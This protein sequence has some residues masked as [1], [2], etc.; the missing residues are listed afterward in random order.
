MQAARS[1]LPYLQVL[2]AVAALVVAFLH[3]E[4]AA[5]AFAGR[6]GESPFPWLKPLP[7]EAGVDI[8]FVISGFVMVWSSMRLFGRRQGARLFLG[9]R[10]ARIVPLYWLTTTAVVLL[11]LT[12]PGALS[13]PLGDDWRYIAASYLFIPWLRPDGYI[14]PAFRLGWTL[15]YE[16][17]FYIIFCLFLPFQ[18]RVAV[19]GVCGVIALLALIGWTVPLGS[20]QLVFWAD[21][22]VLEFAFG[23][24]LG[25]IAVEGAV[26]AAPWRALLVAMAIVLFWLNP[27]EY[28]VVRPISYGIPA[29]LLVAAAVFAPAGRISAWTR[30]WVVLGDASYALYLAHPFPMRALR[31]VWMR[32]HL[33]GSLGIF[34]YIVVSV[35]ASCA[36]SVGINAWFERP[37][38]R[39]ARQFLRA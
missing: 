35:G 25:Y 6:P 36:L 37:A 23:V 8:F 30:S 31:E 7:W 32:M 24:L 4:Q 13:E 22:I 38:T 12:V 33:I 21:P 14:Q 34:S 5:G 27:I 26:L 1:Q 10:I 17:L 39:T 16:M 29:A 28:R 9:R 3:T 2:R 18:R 19:C 15:N 20:P 11:G